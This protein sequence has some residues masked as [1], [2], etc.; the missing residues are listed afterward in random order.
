MINGDGIS[1]LT[2]DV[3][4]V[5]DVGKTRAAAIARTELNRAENQGELQ[6]MKASGREYTK[7]WDAT[8]DNRTSAICNA[9]H[10][11]V[12]A[13]DE[14]FKDHVGGQELDSPP[15]HVNCRSVVEYDVKGP[16][17]RKV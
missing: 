8:L 3:K 10:N 4:G 13:K 15:A 7:R 14:K 2:E 1:K 6:A 12:V 5:F 17:P 9:L 16:K 11:K